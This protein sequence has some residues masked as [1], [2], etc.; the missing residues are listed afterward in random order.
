MGEKKICA[1]E[2]DGELKMLFVEKNSLLNF[3]KSRFNT[4]SGKK[5]QK[6][7][8]EKVFSTFWEF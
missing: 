2:F 6:K 8:K 5:E 1:W 7:K 4:I 3:Y